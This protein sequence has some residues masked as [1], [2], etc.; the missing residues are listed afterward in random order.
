MKRIFLVIITSLFALCFCGCA[1]NDSS[2]NESVNT[3][4]STSATTDVTEKEEEGEQTMRSNKIQVKIGNNAFTIQ[5]EENQTTKAIVQW[6]GEG[7]KTVSA[8]NYGGFEK[9]LSLGKSFPT[10]D[11]HTV[12]EYGDVMLYSGNQIVIFYESNAWSYTRVG[13]VVGEQNLASILS[14]NENE[15]KISLII[16]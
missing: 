13:K 10:N 2:K 5:L 3:N 16:E 8:S 7:E 9:I 4:Q 11:Q 15:V 1:N 6:L 14:G 12:T